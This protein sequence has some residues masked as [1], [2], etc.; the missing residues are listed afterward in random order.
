MTHPPDSG[1]RMIKEA[2]LQNL[3]DSGQRLDAMFQAFADL[4]FVFN[5][6]GTI[7]DYKI[8]RLADFYLP[9]EKVLGRKL[10][11]V[12]PAETAGK[13]S[14]SIFH[15]HDSGRDVAVE[16]MLDIM[17]DEHWYEAHVVPLP[18]ECT[19][20][21][22]RDITKFKRSESKTK[23]QLERLGALRSID[24]AIT[25]GLDLGLTLS[26]ILEHVRLQLEID[27][28]AI[29]LLD[30][31]TQFL[32]FAAGS[33]FKT[34]ALQFTRIR[35]GEGYAGKALLE[36]KVLTIPYLQNRKT[37]F[38]RSP[39]FSQESFVGYYAVPLI[40]KGQSLGVLE[41]FHRASIRA[42]HEWLD[43]MNMIARQAAIA[44]DNAMLFKNLQLSNT[45]LTLAYDKTIEGWSR[46]L[47]LRD[48]E[49]EGHT[50][51]VTETSIKLAIQM[52]I[53]RSELV[54]IHRG[55]MLHDIG[56]VAIPDGIL[57]KPGPLTDEEW[58]IMRRHPLIAME[59]LSPISHLTPALAIPR[60][61]HERW[62]GAGY[63]DGLAGENIPLAA[64][65]F[66]VVDVYDALTSDRPYRSA[67]SPTE[68]VDYIRGESGRHFDPRVISAFLEM[69]GS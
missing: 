69:V 4:L 33:G 11:D 64:R 8:G 54:H 31:N 43:F 7:L 18:G 49:T 9:P 42:D 50:R 19:I 63:P 20:M 14:E 12:F 52:G 28:A 65:I 56:K 62:D 15:A 13:I 47:D 44:I 2:T 24:L 36:R 17:A 29:L 3:P 26:I 53:P 37:D 16:Y 66:A 1:E 32:E 55:A 61:H 45:E 41:I 22:V 59:L 30:Q 35:L 40:A 5:Q 23:S 48:K 60:S 25:S 10:N 6:D 34:N 39:I 46:A 58:A 38:L 27:A 67:W 51:R 21:F 57:L 68:A